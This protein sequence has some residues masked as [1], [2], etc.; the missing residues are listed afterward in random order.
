MGFQSTTKVITLH[1]RRKGRAFEGF[2]KFGPS[3]K[4]WEDT[5]QLLDRLIVE[6]RITGPLLRLK[7]IQQYAEEIVFHA[8]RNTSVGDS[9]VESMLVSSEARQVLYEK[10]VPRYLDRRNLFTRV[11]NLWRTR[12]TDST[13]I[14]MIEFVDRPGEMFPAKPVGALYEGQ[15]T[16]AYEHGNRRERRKFEQEYKSLSR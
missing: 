8:R 1:A 10:L 4:Q 9:V 7:E 12:E 2:R 13:R 14:G 3:F 5:K 15:V 11:V 16:Q 6:Q